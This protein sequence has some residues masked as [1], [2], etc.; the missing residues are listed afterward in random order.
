MGGSHLLRIYV[1]AKPIEIKHL[2]SLRGRGQG[3]HPLYIHVATSEIIPRSI[4]DL[5][6]CVAA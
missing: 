2:E 5:V 1:A 6:H 4:F 3:S